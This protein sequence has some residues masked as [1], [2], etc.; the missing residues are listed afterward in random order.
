M[1]R[2]FFSYNNIYLNH[3]KYAFSPFLMAIDANNKKTDEFCLDLVPAEE[4]VKADPRLP[5]LPAP[6][7]HPQPR[8]QLP[9][10]PP[11]L[12]SRPS[13]PPDPRP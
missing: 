9:Q 6:P 5:L 12:R 4:Q 2:I 8:L 10:G 7:Q 1:I 13:Q 3:K 11:G